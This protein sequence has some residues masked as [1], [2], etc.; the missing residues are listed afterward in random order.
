MRDDL[1]RPPAAA[2]RWSFRAVDRGVVPEQCALGQQLGGVNGP[3]R[4]P[5]AGDRLHPGERLDGTEVRRTQR[6]RRRADHHRPVGEACRAGRSWNCELL[7]P[8]LEFAADDHHQPRTLHHGEG[9]AT[10]LL[11]DGVHRADDGDPLVLGGVPTMTVAGA[12]ASQFRVAARDSMSEPVSPR[13][14]ASTTSASSRVSHAPRD[15]AALAYT[16]AAAKPEFAPV[17]QDRLGERDQLL[18]VAGERGQP[19]LEELHRHAD[20]VHRLAQ[21][22]PAARDPAESPGTRPG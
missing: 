6:R 7:R 8:L 1:R 5:P 3:R 19:L 9:G 2:T 16:E 20:H 11:R 21:R 18:V 4:A 12:V 22:E 17:T 10:V 14:T 15:S 13:T